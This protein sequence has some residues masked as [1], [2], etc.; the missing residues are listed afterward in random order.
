MD[1][2][3]YLI[4]FF[5]KLAFGAIFV[6]LVWWL[7]A[8]LFPA[9]SYT[10]VKQLV[11]GDERK[12]LLPSPRTYARVVA[13][14]PEPSATSNVYVAGKAFDGYGLLSGTETGPLLSYSTDGQGGQPV[15]RSLFVRNMS[16]YEGQKI[17]S[18]YSFFGEARDEMFSNGAFPI[19]VA[20]ANGNFL[21]VFRA[22]S[23]ASWSVPGWTRFEVVFNA[24][25][26]PA[27][28]QPCTL[29]FQQAR[30]QYSN[31]APFRVGMPVTCN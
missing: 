1:A 19:L 17:Y 23:T 15:N 21:G 14:A 12:D 18:G 9:L 3:K 30:E 27:I 7:V 4:G 16:L 8:L 10:Q 25:V 22:S 29:I 6:A 28:S 5:F 26:F 31:Q 2:L 13:S 24:H 20:G 11:F